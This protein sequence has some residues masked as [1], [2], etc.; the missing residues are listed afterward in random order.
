MTS[1]ASLQAKPAV[2]SLNI[3]VDK[4][5]R[6]ELASRLSKV[7]ADTYLLNLKTQNFHWNVVGPH[8]YGLH[9]LTE[10]QYEDMAEAIDDIAERIRAIGHPA[11]G[12]FVQFATLSRIEEETGRPSAEDMIKQLVR[13]N[14]IC[15]RNLREAAEEAENLKDMNTADLLIERIGQHEENI[16]M[17][18]SVLSQ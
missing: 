8:F 16:W 11:P 12:S 3:G 6:Q 5:D 15:C 9:K 18:R 10:A 14:E 13:D 17:L 7:L 4:K 2:S 1:R